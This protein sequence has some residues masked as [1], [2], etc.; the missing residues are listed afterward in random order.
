MLPDTETPEQEDHEEYYRAYFGNDAEY[1]LQKLEQYRE[2]RKITFNIAAFFFGIF[3]ML[4]R[5]MYKQGLIIM[6]ALTV[7]SYLLSLAIQQYGISESDARMLNNISTLFW[8]TLVGFLGN[9][10]YLKQAQAKVEQ[11]LEE[12]DQESEIISRL[13]AEGNITLIPH[14]IIAALIL[15]LILVYQTGLSM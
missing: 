1:Y 7:E 3:W 10:L 14:I 15:L 9:W 5:R 6:V 8:S 13:T 11:A 2:G 12:E 4:Y